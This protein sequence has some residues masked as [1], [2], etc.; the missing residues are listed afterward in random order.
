MTAGTHDCLA[1]MAAWLSHRS[2]KGKHPT[3][4][5]AADFNV[6][7]AGDFNVHLPL[8]MPSHSSA[9]RQRMETRDG[10]IPVSWLISSGTPRLP[11]LHFFLDPAST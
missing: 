2:T 4:F 11:W 3:L 10:S 5:Y 9:Y 1:H 7:Y 8:C 6:F